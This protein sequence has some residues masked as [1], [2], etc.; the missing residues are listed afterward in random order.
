[1]HLSGVCPSICLSV[2][3]PRVCWC[4]PGGQEIS[5]D[6]CTARSSKFGQCHVAD[7]RSERMFTLYAESVGGVAQW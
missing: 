4:G 2:L 7:C 1:M 5:I 3:L 6:C